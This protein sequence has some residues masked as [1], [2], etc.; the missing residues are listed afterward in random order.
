MAES[1]CLLTSIPHTLKE[2]CGLS[3][4]LH[5]SMLPDSL[6]CW[7]TN[8]FSLL[9][10]AALT[11]CKRGHPLQCQPGTAE[12]QLLQSRLGACTA[13]ACLALLGLPTTHLRVAGRAVAPFSHYMACLYSRVLC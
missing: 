2:R 6:A 12:Q 5:A 8:Q 4:C 1:I 3:L 9:G 13:L 10:W 7:R 11:F